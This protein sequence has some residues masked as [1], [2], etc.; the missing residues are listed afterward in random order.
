MVTVLLNP[1]GSMVALSELTRPPSVAPVE[2]AIVAEVA[3]AV[4][5]TAVDEV[6]AATVAEEED[7][8]CNIAY[9]L[10]AFS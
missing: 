8:V 10:T 5:G 6:V 3:V 9:R 1:V 2:E 7:M 4:V